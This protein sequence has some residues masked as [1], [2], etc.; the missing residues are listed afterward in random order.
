MSDR[1]AAENEPA[2]DRKAQDRDLTSGPVAANLL[3]LAGPM[4]F[5]IAAVI[6]V[7]LVDTYFVGRLGTDALAALSFSFPVALTLTSL[8]IGLAAGAA[9]VVSRAVG[10]GEQDRLHRRATD[11]LLLASVIAVLMAGAG[12]LLVRP[13]F[14]LLGAEGDVLELVVAYMRIW[15]VSL[16]FVVVPMVANAMVRA[17]GDAFWPSFI[18]IA[19]SV[20]NAA[21][22]PVL[23]FG[24]CPVPEL[25]IEGA[26]LGTLVARALS[27]L[28]AL[29]LV[30]KRDRIVEARVPEARPFLRSAREVLRIG[31]PAA[32]GNASN[33]AGIAVATAL[34]AVLGSQ[35]V[36]GFGVATRL[37]AFAI[38]PMLA[39]S[40][41]IGPMAG[42]NWGAGEIGRVRR[43]LGIAFAI[44]AAWSLLLAGLFALF[45]ETIAG[46]FASEA[47]VAEEAA[48]YLHIV[49][50]SLWG[51]GVAIVAAGGYN[52]IGKSLTGLAYSLTRIAVFYVPMVWVASRIDGSE[53]V[54]TAIAVANGLGGIAIAW[55]SLS[56]LK[57][58]EAR[59]R[60][61]TADSDGHG[62][63]GQG[64]DRTQQD[65][66]AGVAS[67]TE[68]RTDPASC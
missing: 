48:R 55:H 30:L 4:L 67:A 54:Y 8:S 44:C 17:C 22:T 40:S 26:A 47:A 64:G 18:M 50:I 20:V 23:I 49:P 31:L 16:P 41:A 59:A 19:A 60:V 58:A 15:F 61:E 65:E 33:P 21:V 32:I 29:Y 5:G 56:W 53:T 11:A 34:I 6:S 1:Q 42:Q 12:I 27:L 28:M 46:W 14:Q 24:V 43:A 35:V 39:L 66:R 45:G 7:Q 51:Y 25:G 68:A 2:R 63:Q 13:L 3:R 9:S 38:L 57:K 52:G 62:R 10:E 37:E 36:A